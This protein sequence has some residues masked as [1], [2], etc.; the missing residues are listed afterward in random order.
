[1]C[2]CVSAYYEKCKT[3]SLGLGKCIFNIGISYCYYTNYR[4][5]FSLR[6]QKG[7][8]NI[9]FILELFGKHLLYEFCREQA[10]E[11]AKR[12]MKKKKYIYKYN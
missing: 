10:A 1:M 7:R 4:V 5:L 9:N 8:K 2:V 12:N 3:V 11:V 6:V